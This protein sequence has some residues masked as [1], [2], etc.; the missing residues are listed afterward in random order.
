MNLRAFADA[1]DLMFNKVDRDG[2]VSAYPTTSV[3]GI[4]V[5][6]R[7]ET[8]QADP[9]TVYIRFQSG[10]FGVWWRY[11][12]ADVEAFRSRTEMAVAA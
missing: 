2:L 3:D 7:Q 1:I 9:T 6:V 10:H 11:C 4:T 8:F 5:T 12:A